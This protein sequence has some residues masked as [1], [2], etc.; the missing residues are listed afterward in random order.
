MDTAHH[1]HILQTPFFPANNHHQEQDGNK[2]LNTDLAVKVGPKAHAS[3]HLIIFITHGGVAHLIHIL[4]DP[5]HGAR[6]LTGIGCWL[7]VDPHVECMV[8]AL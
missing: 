8:L 2:D 1:T 6:H 7:D 5:G 3:Q 4:L